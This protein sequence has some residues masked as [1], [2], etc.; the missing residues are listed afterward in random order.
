MFLTLEAIAPMVLG[1]ALLVFA[2]PIADKMRALS[3]N[4]GVAAPKY[5]GILYVWPFRFIAM[6]LLAAGI[7][8]STCGPSRHIM[9]KDKNRLNLLANGKLVQGKVTRAFY[10]HIKPVGWKVIYKFNIPDLGDDKTTYWGS[11]QG[12]RKYYGSLST[13]DAVV[14]IC[15]PLRPQVN[16]EIRYFLNHPHY[17]QTFADAGKLGLL[18]RFE[19]KCQMEQYSPGTWYEMQWQR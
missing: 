16:C 5:R 7:W 9:D 15:D 12:P 4:R 13:G 3:A 2:A 1:A 19:G 18:D 17:R 8:I 6:M 14:V 11:A 10:Q